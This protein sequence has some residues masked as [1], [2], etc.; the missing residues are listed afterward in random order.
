MK[1]Q[2]I[3]T[4][5]RASP[6]AG[7]FHGWCWGQHPEFQQADFGYKIQHTASSYCTDLSS[8]P[9][10]PGH[11]S[12][13][14]LGISSR[15]TWI[16]KLMSIMNQKTYLALRKEK[17]ELKMKVLPLKLA[18][19][20]MKTPVKWQCFG[21]SGEVC[22]VSTYLTLI[23]I[24]ISSSFPWFKFCLEIRFLI[25]P[26][27]TCS[28]TLKAFLA[29]HPPMDTWSSVAALVESESTEEGWHKALF[30]DTAKTQHNEWR[31]E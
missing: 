15:V 3:H 13:E 18:R 27:S 7:S 25:L 14:S 6:V 1:N 24:G 9:G 23:I 12:L 20:S 11:Q 4:P 21:L 30:S 2:W 29:A 16:L 28:I 8:V 10:T 22:I 26:C 31:T 19:A 17:P 5:Q